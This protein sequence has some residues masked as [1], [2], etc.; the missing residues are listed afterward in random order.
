[1][2]RPTVTIVVVA[3]VMPCLAQALDLPR[4][5]VRTSASTLAPVPPLALPAPPSPQQ[6]PRKG[7]K[8]FVAA[9]FEGMFKMRVGS[10][11]VDLPLDSCTE[12]VMKNANPE[13]SRWAVVYPM[14]GNR[15]W[16]EGPWVSRIHR[17]KQECQ[18]QMRAEGEPAVTRSGDTFKL[19]PPQPR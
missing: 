13:R 19:A 1:M 15:I 12:L 8:V 10:Q 7:D 6:W 16:L 17:T 2:K 11:N 3:F 18:S 14:L 9:T 5:E 4:P